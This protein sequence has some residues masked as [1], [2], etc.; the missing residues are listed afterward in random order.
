VLLIVEEQRGG[1]WVPV[2]V[3]C[4]PDARA[5]WEAISRR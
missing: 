3:V 5:A 1:A 2:R 4:A